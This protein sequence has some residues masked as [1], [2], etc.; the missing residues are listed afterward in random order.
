MAQVMERHSHS[1][2]R[3]TQRLRLASR[4]TPENLPG[5]LR[6]P[7]AMWGKPSWQGQGSPSR[8]WVEGFKTW[9]RPLRD[10]GVL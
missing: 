8:I 2:L 3:Y 6:K 5:H 1:Q 10:K 4:L 7:V 9:G